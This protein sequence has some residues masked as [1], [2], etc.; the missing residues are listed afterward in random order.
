MR[1]TTLKHLRKAIASMEA[2]GSYND[3]DLDGA[4]ELDAKLG[5][6]RTLTS[7][8]ANIPTADEI[9]YFRWSNR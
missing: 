8:I 6:L 7:A 1:A 4:I 2:R 5:D 3:Y 9:H